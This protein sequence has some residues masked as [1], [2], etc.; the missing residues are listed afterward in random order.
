MQQ[1]ALHTELILPTADAVAEFILDTQSMALIDYDLDEVLSNIFVALAAVEEIEYRMTGFFQ[2]Y[3]R[4]GD[5]KNT[6]G[7]PD[8]DILANA[9][10]KLLRYILDIYKRIGMWDDSGFCPYYYKGRDHYDCVLGL[11]D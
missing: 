9:F 3:K 2:M 6:F 4:W 5:G 7:I 11:L 8:G 1:I 10:L